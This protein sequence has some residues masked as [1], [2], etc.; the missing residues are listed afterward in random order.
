MLHV[1]YK[2]SGPAVADLLGGQV[3]DKLNRALRDAMKQPDV[4][5][6]FESMGAEAVGSS[7]EQLASHL[8]RESA[9]WGKLITER[10]IRSD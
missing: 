5:A 1:P 3:I 2:G 7:P 10:G 4:A 6:R 8:A 9:R